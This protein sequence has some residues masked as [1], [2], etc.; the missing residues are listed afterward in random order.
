[1]N[2]RHI[3][4]AGNF[5]DVLKHAVLVF[6]LRYLA[7]KDKP[8]FVL[9]THAG[10][11]M[12]DLQDD[13]AERTK[14]AE[15]GIGK[16]WAAENLPEMLSEYRKLVRSFNH[17]KTLRFYP[18]SPK[19]IARMLRANDRLVANE[20]HPEDVKELLAVMR[21]DRNVRVTAEDG[22]T[23]VKA[24]LPPDERRGLV[25]ID[26]PFEVKDEFARM[27]QAMKDALKRW[28]SGMY[29]L[30]YPIK[31]RAQVMMFHAMLAEFCPK[32]TL[33]AELYVHPPE[34]PDRFNGTGLVLVNPPY[35]L[36]ASL[37]ETL[38]ILEQTLTDAR[39]LWRV[40]QLSS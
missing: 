40:T 5:G 15:A 3:Y 19:I 1:M 26:P 16:V 11:G 28:G 23:Q 8:F 22:Y 13:R 37:K 7:Q 36:G 2:Y 21:R 39:G 30:W 32:D 35:T 38:P 6:L 29:A 27:E 33:V 17:G 31:D 4:H 9:D 12:Y 10:I 14:E 18:G 25:F 20:M 34:D 24:L